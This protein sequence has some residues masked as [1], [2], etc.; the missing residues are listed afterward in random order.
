MPRSIHSLLSLEGS[1]NSVTFREFRNS[2]CEEF[3][4]VCMNYML[5]LQQIEPM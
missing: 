2:L 3:V 1:F 5:S 4:T